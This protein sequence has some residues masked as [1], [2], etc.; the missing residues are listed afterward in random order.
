MDL[1]KTL[2]WLLILFSTLK[3]SGLKNYNCENQNFLPGEPTS[4]V[5]SFGGTPDE[6]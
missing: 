1:K 4:I 6:P 2:K 5:F 3:S